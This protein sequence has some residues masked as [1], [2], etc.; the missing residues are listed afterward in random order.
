MG[1]AT[2]KLISAALIRYYQTPS[3]QAAAKATSERQKVLRKHNFNTQ[4]ARNVREARLGRTPQHPLLAPHTL[5]ARAPPGR[6]ARSRPR[7]AR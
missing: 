7:S 2:A 5:S 3:G 4:D 6:A 1:K